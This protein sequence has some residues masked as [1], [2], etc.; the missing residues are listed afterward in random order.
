MSGH[1]LDKDNNCRELLKQKNF[2][3][4]MTIGCNEVWINK[5]NL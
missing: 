5:D 3:F 2:V 1:N 4:D